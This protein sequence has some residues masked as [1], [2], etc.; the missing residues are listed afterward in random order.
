VFY[1]DQLFDTFVRS[2]QSVRFDEVVPRTYCPLF[3]GQNELLLAFHESV[4]VQNDFVTGNPI[5]QITIQLP[6]QGDRNVTVRYE[7]G[8]TEIAISAVNSQKVRVDA[9]LSFHSL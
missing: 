6:K 3:E 1:L 7:F 2:G 4:H 9:K 8:A 5:G